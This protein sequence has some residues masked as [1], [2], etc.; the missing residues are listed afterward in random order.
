MSALPQTIVFQ[1]GSFQFDDMDHTPNG[2]YKP[3]ELG[4]NSFP[5]EQL[6][7]LLLDTLDILGYK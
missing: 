1:T 4:S 3:V 7:K 6:V 2:S 5:K